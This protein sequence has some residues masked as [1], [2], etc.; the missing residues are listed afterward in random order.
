MTSQGGSGVPGNG[1]GRR[2][3]GV[4]LTMTLIV[5]AFVSLDLGLVLWA[6]FR[7]SSHRQSEDITDMRYHQRRRGR[8]HRD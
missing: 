1:Q 4:D 5:L 2:S 8:I 3:S 6:L 7:L